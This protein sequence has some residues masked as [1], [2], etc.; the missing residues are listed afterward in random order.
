[1]KRRSLPIREPRERNKEGCDCGNAAGDDAHTAS[2][3]IRASPAFTKLCQLACKICCEQHQKLLST[4]FKCNLCFADGAWLGAFSRAYGLPECFVISAS[5]ARTSPHLAYLEVREA[6]MTSARHQGGRWLLRRNAAR[7]WA[8]N[9]E[10]IR[11]GSSLQSGLHSR[12]S[13]EHE[14]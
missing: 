4:R 5:V 10:K 3:A 8:V 14:V 11:I 7:S 12:P 9:R 1:L 6:G 2:V 13:L